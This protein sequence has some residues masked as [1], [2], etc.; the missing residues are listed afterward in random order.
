MYIK[1]LNAWGLAPRTV[2]NHVGHI[3]SYLSLVGVALVVNDSM[4]ASRVRQTLTRKEVQPNDKDPI[5][6]HV[7][8]RAIANVPETNKQNAVK[9]A[10]LIMRKSEVV[11]PTIA[12]FDPKRH[13]TRAEWS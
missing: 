11:P 1:A 3:R 8:S 4:V 9:A 5:P 6:L 13:L 12:A 7:L 2:G 10:I